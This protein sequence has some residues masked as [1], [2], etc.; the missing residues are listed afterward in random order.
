[1][2]FSMNSL[3]SMRTIAFSSSN[4]TSASAL[5]SSVLPTPVGPQKDERADRPIA[6]PA[7][8]CGCG[9]RRWRRRR[10]LRPGRSTRWCSRS[11][12]T[13]SLA[14]SVSS[15]RLTGMP[16]H[17]L[18]TSAISSGPTSWRSSRRAAGLAVVGFAAACLAVGFFELLVELL[19]LRCR[20]RTASDKP[21]R[22]R[23]RPPAAP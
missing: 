8:R 19:P 18:T 13:S 3:M 1:M 2:C 14:R 12:S 11:S 21:P 20:A 23:G 6:D 22:R 5:H 9:G 7:G 4:S 15:M 10:P 17:A 16:V